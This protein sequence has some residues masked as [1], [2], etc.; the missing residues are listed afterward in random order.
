MEKMFVHVELKSSFTTALQIQYANSI[1]FIKDSG[2]IFTH[3]K[4]YGLSSEWQER[5]TAAESEIDALQT[6]VAALQAINA[7]TT[8]SDGTNTAS[9][10]STAKTIKFNAGGKASVSV[11]ADGVTISASGTTLAEGTANGQTSVDGVSKSIV[12][13]LDTAAYHSEDD[14]YSAT[15]GAAAAA[16]AQAAQAAA[17]SKVASVAATTGSAIEVTGTATAPTVG[18]KLDT[19]A[20]GNV[21]LSQSANGLKASVEIPAATVTGVAANDKVLGL[22]GTLLSSTLDLS[23]NSTT[24]KIQLL[25]IEN[26]VIAEVDASDFIK[27][28]MV[29]AVSFDPTSKALTITFNTDSGQEAIEVDLSSLVDTYTAGNGIAIASNVV[30]IK[31]DPTSEAF[32]SVGTAGVK[33]SGVQSAID[34]AKS[35]VVGSAADISA[36][37]TVYGA[38]A[39]ADALA[40][41]YATADQGAKADTALQSIAKGTDG[42]YVTTTV[43]AKS[44]NSQTIATSVTVQAISS[45]SSTAKGLAEASDVKSYVDAL[46]AWEEL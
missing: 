37:N 6:A 32:L 31:V 43:G 45:A 15:D 11:G 19:L 44:N 40:D 23:Y 27:D 3:G 10:T 9:A 41:N 7:F 16:A 46:F 12:K 35:A 38:K 39:Y 33:I 2:E 26:A 28:G 8:I 34:V 24:K 20:P 18:L 17:D 30:S 5:I 13:G 21:T 29:N 42:S 1:V 22:T 4:F 36:S 14:F 25:G